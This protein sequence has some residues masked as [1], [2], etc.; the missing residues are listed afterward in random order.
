[1]AGF[2]PLSKPKF[3]VETSG[4]G[5]RIVIPAGRN[6]FVMLFLPFWLVMWTIGGIAAMTQAFSGND[7]GFLLVWLCFWAV[8]WLFAATWLGWQATGKEMLSIEGG[9]L[10][11][12]WS[13]LGA[14]RQRKYD[15]AHVEDLATCTPPFPYNLMRVSY[16]PFFPISFGPLKWNYGAATIYAGGG[17]SEAEARMVVEHLQS[18]L[19]A[20]LRG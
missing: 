12:G 3:R 5:E 20:R 9:A 19:P 7:T 11:R 2:E 6:W 15:L 14:G 18:R 10:V 4:A 13:I 16:P 17:L 8:G 1:M